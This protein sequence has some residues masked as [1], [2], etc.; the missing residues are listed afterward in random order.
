MVEDARH[1]MVEEQ[2]RARGITDPRILQAFLRVPR[3]LFV[4]P[5]EAADAYTDHPMLIGH[6]Q[7]ISQPYMVALMTSLLRLQ[8]HERVLEIGTGSGYQLAILA[9]LALEIFSV[10]RVQELA[11]Q[12]WRRLETLGYRNVHILGGDGTLGWPD[13]ALYDGIIVTA[14][15]QHVPPPLLEQ[16]RD[17]GRLVIPIGPQDNQTLCLIQKHRDRLET[18]QIAGCMFVPLIGAFGWPASPSLP[19]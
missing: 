16:L 5:E 15:A 4:P 17:G 12:A 19:S 9:E 1:R 13:H 10:E 18:Q 11:S 14:G 8:G 3:H 2:L 7:T 6:Q